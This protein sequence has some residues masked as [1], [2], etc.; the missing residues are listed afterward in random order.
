MY[1]W[2]VSGS[3]SKQSLVALPARAGEAKLSSKIECFETDELLPCQ[4]WLLA[5]P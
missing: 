1:V 5:L 3:D 4:W 2:R